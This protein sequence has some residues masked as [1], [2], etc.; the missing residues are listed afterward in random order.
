[1]FQRLLLVWDGSRPSQRALD[2]AIGIARR[3][4]AEIVAVSVAHSP[5]HAE[6][7]EDRRE[8]IDAVRRYVEA[9]FERV[10]DRPER[11]GVRI[12]QVVLEAEQPVE[13]LVGYAHEH[14]FDLVLVG[15][16]R[17]RRV[18]RFFLRGLA[19]RMVAVAD[20]PVLIVSDDAG[21]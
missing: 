11:A 12:V 18:G 10:R 3:Y 9:S 21:G 14:G 2:L 7:E 20:L 1:M 15:H 16:H 13:E 6:T 4:D 19:E 5:T 8:S 17:T